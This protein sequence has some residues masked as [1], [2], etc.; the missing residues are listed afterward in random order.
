MQTKR[1][2]EGTPFLH[3]EYMI[4]CDCGSSL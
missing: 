2:I 4:I 3:D 1:P